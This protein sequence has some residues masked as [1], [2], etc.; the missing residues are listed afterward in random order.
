MKS[1]LG[2]STVILFLTAGAVFGQIKKKPMLPQ[3]PLLQQYSYPFYT[4]SNGVT[5]SFSGCFIKYK[6]STYFVTA[7]HH[8]YTPVNELRKLSNVMI[9]VDHHNTRDNTRA[10]SLNMKTQR[11]I[12]VCKDS[13][14]TDIVLLP[15]KIPDEYKIHYAEL[16]SEEDFEGKEMSIVGYV[17]DTS[18]II[19]TKFYDFL[20]RDNNYFLTENSNTKDQSGSPVLMVSKS[21]GVN[22]IILAGIYSGRELSQDN[23]NKGLVSRAYLIHDVFEIRKPKTANPSRPIKKK[24]KSGPTPKS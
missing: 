4:I 16:D 10:L 6:D 13:V 23:F 1:V 5:A 12:P 7:R 21:K 15:I 19:E 17:Q 18:N 2:V 11:V 3:G 24:T 9:F 20:Q 8:F 22:R 14:C